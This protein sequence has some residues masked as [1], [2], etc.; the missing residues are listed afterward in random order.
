MS[1]RNRSKAANPSKIVLPITPMLDMT[2][3]L[4]FF[5]I[6]NFKGTPPVT[7]IEGQLDMALP[8]QQQTTANPHD[9]LQGKPDHDPTVEFPA[10]LTVQVGTGVN[11]NGLIDSLQIRDNQGVVDGVNGGLKGLTDALIKRREGGLQQKANIK[12]QGDGKLKVRYLVQVMDACRRAG[13]TNVSMV[14]PEGFRP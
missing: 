8:S 6:V 11:G 12:V 1:F 9:K 5:F 4:L 10:D 2:F 13:F 14:P 7:L 3:Q